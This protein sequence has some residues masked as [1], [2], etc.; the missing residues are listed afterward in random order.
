MIYHIAGQSEWEEAAMRGLYQ[1]D[2]LDSDGFI[3]CSAAHQVICTAARLFG[4]R[5]DLVLLC[6]DPSQVAAEIRW[7]PSLGDEEYPHIYGPLNVDAVVQVFDFEP[8]ADGN[9][10]LPAG[11]LE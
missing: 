2:T 9:F 8:G 5:T 6:V 4:G 7:E 11:L 10:R 1:G 3:H